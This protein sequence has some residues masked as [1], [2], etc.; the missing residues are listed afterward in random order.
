MTMRATLSWRLKWS[1][2]YENIHITK[3]SKKSYCSQKKK[4][5][6]KKG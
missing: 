4:K 3:K 2:I 5:K 6:S 1:K